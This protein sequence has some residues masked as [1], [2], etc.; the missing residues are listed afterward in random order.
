MAAEGLLTM[1]SVCQ[2]DVRDAFSVGGSIPVVF[3]Y[4]CELVPTRRRGFYLTIVA[5]FWMVG[6]M[7]VAGLA[8][9]LLAPNVRHQRSYASV[10]HT[11]RRACGVVG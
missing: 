1:P 7:L 11:Q 4:C 9:A 6:A 10:L 3:A 8:W 5:A 2:A